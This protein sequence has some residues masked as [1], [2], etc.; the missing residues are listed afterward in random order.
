MLLMAVFA[1]L[2]HRYTGKKDIIIGSP[3]SRRNRPELQGLIGLFIDTK[4]FVVHVE[5]DQSFLHHLTA[6]RDTCIAALSHDDVTLQQLAAKGALRRASGA[7]SLFGVFVIF[8]PF[9]PTHTQ[10]AGLEIRSEQATAAVPAARCLLEIADTGDAI[11]GTLHSGLHHFQHATIDRVLAHFLRLLEAAVEDP[12][13]R[14]NDL[15]MMSAAERHEI[16]VTWNQTAAS[17]P[18]TKCLHHLFEDQVNRTP[19]AIAVVGNEEQLTFAQLNDRADRLAKFLRSQGVGADTPVGLH[20]DRSLGALVGL[21]GILKAGG[22]YVPM[23]IGSP[24]ARYAA[25]A[26]DSGLALLVASH[27]NVAVPADSAYTVVFADAVEFDQPAF[28]APYRS[29]DARPDSLACILYTSGSTGTPRGV[30]VE[31]R[32]LVNLMTHRLERQFDPA[33][34]RIAALTSPLNFDA[35]ITQIFSPLLTGGMLVIAS[36]IEELVASP[37]FDRLTAFT[38]AA[39]VITDLAHRRGLPAS[40]RIVAVG[41]EPVPLRLLEI[42]KDHPTAQRLDVLFGLTECSGYSTTATLFDRS[43]QQAASD[44]WSAPMD[45]ALD[46]RIIGRP[47]ANTQVYVLDEQLKPLPVGVAGELFIGGDGLTRGFLGDSQATARRFVASPFDANE[48]LQNAATAP[49]RNREQLAQPVSRQVRTTPGCSRV[50]AAR[51]ALA[52][53]QTK[54]H[55][56]P[57]RPWTSWAVSGP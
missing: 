39:T 26:Q 51:F 14:I 35:S 50:S 56:R 5:P 33:H 23:P 3:L 13:L 18:R 15:P 28:A 7:T 11:T 52:L 31:H 34:F 22:A 49:Q 17:Y 19:N 38:G 42:V 32:G 44:E 37:W 55:L 45:R 54:Q 1:V 24:Q 2:L 12:Q 9:R 40:V 57:P 47:I 10:T 6:I 29:A 53:R 48:R 30:C 41:G 43:A 8:E 20:G 4:P 21:L 16:L 36:G 25:V 46:L 27:K